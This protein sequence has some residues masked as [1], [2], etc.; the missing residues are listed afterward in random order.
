MRAADSMTRGGTQSSARPRRFA[1][2]AVDA[3]AGQHQV[4]GRRRADQR[5][6][7]QHAA[8][9]GDDA[10][11][12]LGQRE[13]GAGFVDDDAMAAGERELQT[14]SHAMA[15]DQCQRRVGHR[16]EA[17][18]QQPAALDQHARGE[19]RIQP[20]ELLDVGAGDEPGRL[21]GSDHQRLG[22]RGIERVEHAGEFSHYLGR[23][24][25]GARIR[26]IQ[27]QPG[28]P[29]VLTAQAPVLPVLLHVRAHNT[30]STSIAP[31][32]PPPM[33]IDARPRPPPLRR[34]TSSR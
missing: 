1:F 11:H 8:P 20:R 14:A 5:G 32:C 22:R 12:D 25:I 21:G 29:G 2:F 27:I 31:P 23:Q 17:V 26:L 16:G 4:E 13:L 28:Q 3:L 34:N 30:V 18:E 19:H 10:E 33:Q 24:H 6:Q 7:A 15:A 9:A